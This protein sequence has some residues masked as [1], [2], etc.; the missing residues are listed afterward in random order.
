MDIAY[1]KKGIYKHLH[2]I[3]W[4]NPSTLPHICYLGL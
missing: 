1:C 4:N 2:C 3:F